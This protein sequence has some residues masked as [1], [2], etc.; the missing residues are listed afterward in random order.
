MKGAICNARK[1]EGNNERYR[2]RKGLFALIAGVFLAS[3]VLPPLPVSAM[4]AREHPKPIRIGVL[5]KRGAQR[6]MRK[7]GPTAEYLSARVPGYSFSIV[8]LGFDEIR[9][10]AESERI[11][12]ILA[13]PAIYVELERI[14]GATRLATL[15]NLRPGKAYT[16]YGGVIFRRAD[17]N[18]IGHFDDLVGK[19]FMAVK[20][21]SFGGWMAPWREL[22]AHGV[23]PHRDFADLRFGGTH[24]AVVYA[25]RDGTVDAGSVRTDTLERM[26]AEGKIRLED[27][28][29]TG[30]RNKEQFPFLLSTRLYPE[31]PLAELPHVSNRLAE[32]VAVALI[33]M[34][35]DDPAAK[36]AR[37]AGWT[38]PLNYQPVHKCLKEL[39]IGPYKDYGKVTLGAAVRRYWPW[40]TGGVV[41]LVLACMVTVYVARLNGAMKAVN[42]ALSASNKAL[43]H[44]ALELEAQTEE[45]QAL[46]EQYKAANEALEEKTRL[47]ETQRAE[48]EEKNATL[49]IAK[50]EIEEK[51]R[52]LEAVSQYKS[53]FLANVSHEIRTPMTVILG[54]ADVLL[55]NLENTAEPEN[56]E[57]ANTIKRNGKYLLRIINDILNLGKIDAGKLKVEHIFC[58][59]CRIVSDVVSLMRVRA[60]AKGLPLEVEYDGPIPEL[61][62]SDSTR[63]RQILINLMGNAVKFTEVGSVRLVTR[64]LDRR[65]DQPKIQFEI[66]DTGIG[67]TEEQ[68]ARLFQPFSQA[69]SST[70]RNFGGIGLGLTI[71]KRLTNVLGGDIAVRST[72]GQGS[73]FTVTIATGPLDGIRLLDN[74]TEV[75]LSAKQAKKSTDSHAR[76]DCRVLLAEDGPDNQ[77]LISFV[78]EKAGAEVAVAEN[79]QIA[80][81]LALAARNEEKPFDVILMDMQMP[82]LDGYDATRKLREAGYTDPIIAMT[83]HSM[84]G[85]RE[86]C[87]AAGCDD[88]AAKPIDR[89]KLLSLIAQYAGSLASC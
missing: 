11:D 19:T 82:V 35:P 16:V 24:D 6:C 75:A 63:L 22:K 56:V 71:S 72:P 73:T 13:N 64:L 66:V 53:E 50:K 29:V 5:A 12:F 87:I 68:I 59:P 79:G 17:R 15:K 45:A 76:L 46:A 78:L 36:A 9:P 25:V 40:L 62:R 3:G 1:E 38:V 43:G 44:Q 4:D 52:E 47:L 10:A 26:A 60:L 85:D 67:M 34:F 80:L 42:S 14:C 61:I 7:W 2:F 20:E 48:I 28:R 57:A 8:P 23:D 69:D 27:F 49:V 55:G 31:W 77:R 30:E 32:Q 54:F 88:Y 39:R 89:K 51:A 81:D 41:L 18:D 58:S 33:G 74:P 21:T 65:Q 70:T 83:A 37:C 86:K 84:S